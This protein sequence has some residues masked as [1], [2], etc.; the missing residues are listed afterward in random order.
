MNSKW[1]G[2]AQVVFAVTLALL[3]VQ[4][5]NDQV[6]VF[7][8]GVVCGLLVSLPHTGMVLWL[9]HHRSPTGHE[10]REVQPPVIVMQP[11]APTPSGATM[12]SMYPSLPT[13]QPRLPRDFNIIGEEGE[14]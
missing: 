7:A 6:L 8:A 9:T 3:V 13:P 5:L 4:R 10:T 12:M 2:L 14:E 11:T 1:T